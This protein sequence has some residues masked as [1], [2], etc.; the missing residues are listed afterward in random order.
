MNVIAISI[1]QTNEDVR[2]LVDKHVA[3]KRQE[4]LI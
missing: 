3:G 4:T 1:G 2:S